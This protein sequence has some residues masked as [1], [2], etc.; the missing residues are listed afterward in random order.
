[1]AEKGMKTM[2]SIHLSLP[3]DL[4]EH[5]KSESPSESQEAM[6]EYIT[7]LVR[8]DQARKQSER[9]E[10][11]LIDGIRSGEPITVNAAYWEEKHRRLP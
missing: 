3:D 9:L 4:V 11:L 6:G 5:I 1:M 2:T 7:R 8:E 10:A